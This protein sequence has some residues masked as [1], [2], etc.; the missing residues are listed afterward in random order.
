MP[1][2]HLELRKMTDIFSVEERS[3]IMSRVKN[4][5]TSP[6]KLVRGFLHKMGFRYR[7]HVKK[8]PGNP[9]IVLPRHKKIIFVH[10]CFWHGH[11]DC[12]RAT[13]PTS[14]I[15]FWNKKID[16]NMNRD[17][18]IQKTLKSLGWKILI[19]WQCQTRDKKILLELLEKFM[20]DE[21]G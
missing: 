4:R 17:A 5:D 13:R 2:L 9:D 20:F 1:C 15:E 11:K 14:N 3:L 6:E 21:K 12:S 18:I 8:L 10:G 7:L 19:I 16:G